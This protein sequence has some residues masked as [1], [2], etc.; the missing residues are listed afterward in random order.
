MTPWCCT[1]GPELGLLLAGA[2]ERELAPF[3]LPLDDEEPEPLLW[4]TAWPLIA[5]G[6]PAVDLLEVCAVP[7]TA[8]V[9]CCT[10][11][12]ADCTAVVRP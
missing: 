8:P 1:T 7:F 2:A 4:L 3:V 9:P 12:A 11:G 6:E 5:T 10:T